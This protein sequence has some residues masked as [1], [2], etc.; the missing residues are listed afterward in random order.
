M[1]TVA[2][3]TSK[4]RIRGLHEYCEPVLHDQTSGRDFGR[5]LHFVSDLGLDLWIRVEFHANS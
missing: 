2:H 1:V 4:I 5:Y 3:S